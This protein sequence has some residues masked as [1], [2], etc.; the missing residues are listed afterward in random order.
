MVAITV[1]LAAVIAA[2]VLDMGSGVE[3]NAQAGANVEFDST[4]DEISI[5]Y[6]STQNADYIKSEL[7]GGSSNT[8]YLCSPGS[9]VTYGSSVTT[10]GEVENSAGNCDG[11]TDT[12][13][14]SVTVSD[15]TSYDV[16]VTAVKGDTQTVIAEESDTL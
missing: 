11:T 15:S 14:S 6:S 5:T 7:S 8:A 3:Q 13:P 4:N 1:I 16:I 12:A 2:F 9:K 10:S